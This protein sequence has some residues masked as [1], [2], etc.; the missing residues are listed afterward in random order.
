MLELYRLKNQGRPI[1]VLKYPYTNE[2]MGNEQDALEVI[3]DDGD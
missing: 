2:G 3:L 1:N